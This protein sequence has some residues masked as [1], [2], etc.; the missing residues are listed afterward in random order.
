V[1]VTAQLIEAATGK[2]VWAE[3][4]DRQL[5]DIL[6]VQDEISRKIATELGVKLSWGELFRYKALSTDNYQAL[7]FYQQADVHFTRLEKGGNL[8][9][10]ELLEKA[11]ALDPD[12]SR[13]IAFLGWT[14]LL[15]VMY[16]WSKDPARSLALAE[17]LAQRAIAVDDRV[18]LGH[19]LQAG[20]HG[21]KGNFEQA[22]AAGE[23]AVEASP[24]HVIAIQSLANNLTFAGR[25]EEAV[26]L[27]RKALRLSPYPPSYIRGN[28]G[29]AHYF[30]GNH[31]EAAKT[32]RD[33][34]ALQK[35]GAKARLMRLY[36]IASY[37]ELGREDDAREVVE[38]LLELKPDFTVG[39]A[40]K[41]F[42]RRP[43]KDHSF[44]KRMSEQWRQ[45]GLPE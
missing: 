15:E 35:Q 12:F 37:M 13:A 21:V 11:L 17:E 9:A 45:A 28:A 30:T 36:L 10:R 31:E 44:V 25:A 33:Y 41:L 42:K 26:V 8:R 27:Y 7:D 43:F 29:R 14:H 39:A 16:G 20:I 6:A 34:L 19:T 23:R 22:I 4:Y 32:F 1:R 24:N 38:D 18:Y 5:Q 3:S 2:Q 40:V